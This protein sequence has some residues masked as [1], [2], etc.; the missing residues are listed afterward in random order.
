[1]RVDNFLP[2]GSRDEGRGA[3]AK[4]QETRQGKIPLSSPF[5]K[6]GKREI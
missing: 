3:R 2:S 5:A 6:G 1:V 4:Q